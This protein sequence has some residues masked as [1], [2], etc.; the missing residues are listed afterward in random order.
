MGAL[1]YFFVL[2]FVSLT[3]RAAASSH[4]SRPRR[5]SR[6]AEN[7]S[8]FDEKEEIEEQRARAFELESDDYLSLPMFRVR[9][10]L[11]VPEAKAV[12]VNEP[13]P[14]VKGATSRNGRMKLT[15][16][17]PG[18]E[19]FKKRPNA[20]TFRHPFYLEPSM[21]SR[22][23]HAATSPHSLAPT[24]LNPSPLTSTSRTR[25]IKPREMAKSLG[26]SGIRAP[27][28]G[29]VAG[30]HMRGR[31]AGVRVSIEKVESQW[32]AGVGMVGYP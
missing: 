10:S 16:V 31:A 32:R 20:V 27:F 11:F 19:N 29:S 24:K 12:G 9:R 14:P 1:L 23:S 25:L 21:Q 8:Q 22:A 17:I 6:P 26:A 2:V 3:G 18:D 28:S 13:D 30:M 5:L 4:V 15:L 7:A